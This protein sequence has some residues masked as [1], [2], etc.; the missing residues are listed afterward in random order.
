MNQVD[1]LIEKY[2]APKKPGIAIK[3]N[4]KLWSKC[5]SEAKSKMGGKHSA[6]AMQLALKLYKQRG[7]KFKGH[8]SP[9]N[10]L[11]QWSSKN[12]FTAVYQIVKLA[13]YFQ[14]KYLI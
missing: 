1:R 6:R 14:N 9:K 10:K 3:T 11:K 13:E 8:K 7:G 5:K 2:S 4:P 12:S